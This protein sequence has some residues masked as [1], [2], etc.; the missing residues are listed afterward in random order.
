MPGLLKQ[1]IQFLPEVRQLYTTVEDRE[2]AKGMFNCYWCQLE[3]KQ[4]IHS[5]KKE[6]KIKKAKTWS[7]NQGSWLIWTENN[8]NF[9]DR[10]N[11]EPISQV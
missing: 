8:F 3:N 7:R 10:E 6:K 11:S 9:D 5:I 4:S 1:S 2:L